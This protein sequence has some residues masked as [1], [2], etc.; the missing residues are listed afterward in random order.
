MFTPNPGEI[1]QFEAHIFQMGGFLSSHLFFDLRSAF[2]RAQR[3]TIVGD[4]LQ[5]GREEDEDITLDQLT[6]QPALDDMRVPLPLQAAVQEIFTNSWNTVIASGQE[7]DDSVME[8]Q[9]GTRP[10]DPIA[11]LAFTCIMRSVLKQFMEQAEDIL[12]PLAVDEL[13][14]PVPAITWVD[15]VAIFLQADTVAALVEKAS[16][17]VKLMHQKCRSH[18]LD[19]NYAKGKTEIM[20]KFHGRDAVQW[21]KKLHLQPTIDL[22]SGYWSNIEVP[23]STKYTHLGVV[24]SAK[25]THDAELNYRLGRARAAMQ[26]CM[27]PVLRQK[28]IPEQTRWQLAKSLILSRLFFAAELWPT[29]SASQAAKVYNFMMKIAR[30]ILCKENFVGMD[31]YTDQHIEAHLQIPALETLLRAARL[32]HLARMWHLGPE[33][34]RRLLLQLEMVDGDAWMRLEHG[35]MWPG[36]NREYPT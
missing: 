23:I 32:R 35:K 19:L 24:H 10:G 7:R 13:T 6:R 26:E 16:D 29:L 27:K 25:A 15:D 20:F 30:I 5:Y 1:I 33:V 3:S 21:R 12:P 31:H 9:R 18:G 34:L 11:D 36:Y 17:T 8:S 4:V 2:Y 14:Q 22:G 28:A